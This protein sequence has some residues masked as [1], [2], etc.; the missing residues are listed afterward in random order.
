MALG[1]EKHSLSKEEVIG[2]ALS[3]EPVFGSEKFIQTR[4]NSFRRNQSSVFDEACCHSRNVYEKPASYI[5]RTTVR[6]SCIIEICVSAER[7]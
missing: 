6:L 5:P 7:E 4:Q 1:Y 2:V 3:I